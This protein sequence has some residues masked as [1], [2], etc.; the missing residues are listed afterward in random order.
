MLKI[1]QFFFSTLHNGKSFRT[2]NFINGEFISSST[3][4]KI[5]VINPSNEEIISYID[6]ASPKEVDLAIKSAKEAFSMGSWASSTGAERSA[7]LSKLADLLEKNIS[8]IAMIESL[9]T[10][11]PYKMAKNNDSSAAINLLRYYAGLAGKITGEAI[12]VSGPYCCYTKPEPIGVCAQIIPWNFP[13]VGVAAKIAPALATGCTIVLKPSELTPFS[14]LELAALFNEAGFPR[15]VINI[16]NGYG[17]TTGESLIKHPLVDKISFTGSTQ[18][19]LHIL[20]E[21]HGDKL[22]KLSLELGGKSPLIV[23]PDFNLE[24]AVKQAQGAV[25]YNS[26]QI[27]IAGSR[28][29]VHEKIYKDFVDLS[30][31]MA[32]EKCIG[33][34]LNA[35]TELGPLISQN[36]REKYLHYVKKGIEQGARLI[37]GG[38]A[39][40]GKG[41][42]VEPTVFSDVT[43]EMIIA[44][45][46]IF[47]PIMSILKFKHID[48]VIE[49]ANKTSYGLVG[50]VLTNNI[51][52]AQ[53][54]IDKLH[55]GTVWVNCYGVF[56]PS[57][58]FGGYKNSG[59]GKE[60]GE[61][62]M[63]EYLNYKTVFIKQS[64]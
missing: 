58:P 45:E 12:P 21:C 60:H 42:F 15:G 64:F 47:A 46:E 39:I 29:F 33:D 25:F 37:T 6:E 9:N 14:A 38:N 44:K 53:K 52:N 23:F 5:P 61:T 20:K 2:K 1:K 22:K 32:K 51:D 48:E 27:C 62:G 28:L 31:Q 50:G 40:K 56:D 54:I 3:S 10:G 59:I 26:G 30:C 16:I 43:D 7:C 36:Q 19:G 35:K 55:C 8:L 57:A 17:S 18:T 34:P 63:R 24:T 4:K 11:K 49:R 13:L 41:F